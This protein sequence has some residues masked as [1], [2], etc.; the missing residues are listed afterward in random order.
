MSMHEGYVKIMAVDKVYSS[1]G[2]VLFWLT[3]SSWETDRQETER[4]LFPTFSVGCY[5]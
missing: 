3:F 2:S 5:A 4:V 1:V